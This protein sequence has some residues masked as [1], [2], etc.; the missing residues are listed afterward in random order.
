MS[1]LTRSQGLVAQ[2]ADVRAQLEKVTLENDEKANQ[3]ALVA[4]E[5]S[6]A[7]AHSHLPVLLWTPV[8]LWRRDHS[9]I[10]S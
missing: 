4:A 3:L 6:V 10:T 9:T 7:S 1:T 2:L 5:K 8:P